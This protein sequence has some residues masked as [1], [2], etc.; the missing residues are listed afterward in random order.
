MA[1]IAET[2]PDFRS[3]SA[4][5][6]GQNR[7]TVGIVSTLATF[8]WGSLAELG[9]VSGWTAYGGA[10][11][12]GGGS[13]ATVQYA[14]NNG[15]ID[16]I[17][18]SVAT[19]TATLGGAYLDY[20]ATLPV[21][22]IIRN[23]VVN[24][25]GLVAINTTAA[26]GATSAKNQIDGASDSVLTSGL[27]AAAGTLGG[28]VMGFGLTSPLGG[29]DRNPVVNNL[30]AGPT[31]EYINSLINPPTKDDSTNTNQTKTNES[32]TTNQTTKGKLN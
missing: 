19:I 31:Q 1:G 32:T 11:L 10:G 12:I 23:A 4:V 18:V 17:D 27:G 29:P 2:A 8:G 21:S 13:N 7:L 28:Y 22:S 9:V 25:L 3:T 30:F 15:K 14:T 5:E 26:V 6:K 20:I 16:P 24:P